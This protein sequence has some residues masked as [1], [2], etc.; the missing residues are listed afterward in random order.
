MKQGRKVL[1]L[2]S[3]LALIATL[4]AALPAQAARRTATSPAATSVKAKTA[5][6]HQFTG[7]VTALDKTTLTV[8]KG[9]KKPRTM[10]FTR[11]ADMRTVG[12]LEKDARVTVYYREEGRETVAVRV[13]VKTSSAG[14]SRS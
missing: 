13:V 11:H 2:G 14:A 6:T 12:D 1:A 9:G 5:T 3:A 10:V 7:V 4:L 8:E